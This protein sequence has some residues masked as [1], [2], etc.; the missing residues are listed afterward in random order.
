MELIKTSGVLLIICSIT[1]LIVCLIS[2]N[3]IPLAL[4]C[5]IFIIPFMF[6]V[7]LVLYAKKHEKDL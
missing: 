3:P 1:G 2:D 5:V 7:G 6:G 4:S